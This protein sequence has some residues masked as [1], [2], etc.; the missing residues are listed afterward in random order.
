MNLEFLTVP[1]E[2]LDVAMT[3]I[4]YFHQFGYTVMVERSSI[5]YPY[6]PTLVCKRHPTTVIVDVEHMIPLDRVNDWVAY[7]RSCWSD[8]RVA[9]FLPASIAI[10]VNDQLDL[11]RLGVGIYLF[12]GNRVV[13]MLVPADLAVN[14]GL[15]ALNRYSNKVRKSLGGSFEQIRRGNWREGFEDACVAL[16]DDARRYLTKHVDSGRIVTVSPTG[17]VTTP[18]RKKIDGMTMGGLKTTFLAIRAPNGAD[19][20]IAGVLKRLNPDRIRVAHKR[21]SPQAEQALRRNVGRQLWTIVAGVK[22]MVG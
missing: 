1:E 17:N 12:D 13:E 11:Q 20:K 14:I 8:T 22:E 4:D 2:L 19:A 21:R 6:T 3:S 16:E 7:G 15:P 9:L 5:E 10:S 18:S